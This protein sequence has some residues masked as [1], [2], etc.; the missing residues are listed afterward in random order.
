MLFPFLDRAVSVR[1]VFFAK[2]DMRLW[3]GVFRD[4]VQS[5][6]QSW[7]VQED[8]EH[9]IDEQVKRKPPLY[10]HGERRKKH[11]KEHQK[12]VTCVHFV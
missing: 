9:N 11:R 2:M 12:P 1:C 7:K 3:L 8:E 10:R 5:M 4:N 6:N